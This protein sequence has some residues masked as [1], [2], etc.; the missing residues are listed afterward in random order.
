M[1]YE[2]LFE[3]AQNTGVHSKV[4]KKSASDAF[5]IGGTSLKLMAMPLGDTFLYV[6]RNDI[7]NLN[8]NHINVIKLIYLW[9]FTLLIHF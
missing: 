2:V 9:F 6:S 8:R 4:V 1:P 3:Y 7:V 5:S